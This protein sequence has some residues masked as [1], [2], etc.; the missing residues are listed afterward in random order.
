M[1]RS[2]QG[3]WGERKGG[4]PLGR[5]TTVQNG[6]VLV[7]VVLLITFYMLFAIELARGTAQFF[8]SMI[9]LVIAVALI[10]IFWILIR[11]EAGIEQLNEAKGRGGG[12]SGRER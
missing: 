11:I 1:A 8:S 7:I 3:L 2:G 9:L 6:L 4:A 10:A 12:P 5:L